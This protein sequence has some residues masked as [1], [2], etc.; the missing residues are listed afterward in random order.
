MR[1]FIGLLL[2]I[3]GLSPVLA[4][5]VIVW[6]LGDMTG[7]LAAALEAPTAAIQADIETV[8]ATVEA[9]RV[10]FDD[11]KDDI[12][13]LVNTIA[14]F[15]VPDFLPDLPDRLSLPTIEIPNF[16]VTYPNGVNVQWTDASGTIEELVPN[17]CGPLDFLCDAFR[18]I[19]RAVS[20]RYPSGVSITTGSFT[21][22]IP[23]VPNVS[24][25]L[26]DVFGALRSG[27]NGLFSGFDGIFDLFDGAFGSLRALGDEFTALGDELSQAFGEARSLASSLRSELA[28][29]SGLIGAAVVICLALILVSFVTGFLQDVTRG[30]RMLFRPAP[31]PPGGG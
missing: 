24:I 6:G 19:T 15:Q 23:D 26:P 22:H 2:V 5:A 17:D 7:A 12:S 28:R 9:A 29:W 27:L 18:T 31:E 4:A 8:R 1:R 11:V 30:L 13:T 20:I 21:I 16:T 10:Q 14:R 3:R 25:P